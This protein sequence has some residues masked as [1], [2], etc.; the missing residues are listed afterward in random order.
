MKWIYKFMEVYVWLVLGLL[1]TFG[2]GQNAYE[3][4]R[5]TAFGLFIMGFIF[6]YVFKR[7]NNR[8]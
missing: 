4:N 1:C 3:G 5:L 8:D 2:A 7:E 6:L